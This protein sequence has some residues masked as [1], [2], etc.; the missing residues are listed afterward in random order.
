ME[1]RHYQDSY[2]R[3]ACSDW[4][5]TLLLLTGIT[6]PAL[7]AESDPSEVSVSVIET[8][9][10]DDGDGDGYVDTNESVQLWLTLRNESTIDYA[11]LSIMV[12]TETDL[13]AC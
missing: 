13:I 3:H 5:A 6:A 1:T 8:R 7:G 11:D 9:Y 2:Y 4:L 12:G 10:V